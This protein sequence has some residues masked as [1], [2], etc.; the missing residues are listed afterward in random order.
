MKLLMSVQRHTEENY[1][2]FID[3]EKMKSMNILWNNNVL[4]NKSY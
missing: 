1:G 2:N 3:F 4:S